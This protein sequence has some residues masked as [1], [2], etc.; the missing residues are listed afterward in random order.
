MSQFW[1]ALHKSLG[2]E[3][4]ASTSYHPQ[5]DGS[6]ERSNKTVIQALR[7]YVNRRQTD[8]AKHLIHVETAMN[9]SVNA[10]TEL[11]PTEL[12][13][14]SPIRLFPTL[15]ETN[16]DDAQLPDV[17]SYID[18]I[19]ESI[20]IAKDNH[21][22]AKTIQ[23]RNANRSR[24]PDPI[25]KVGDMVMLDSKNIRRRITKNGR[26]AKLYP[27]FL[28]PFKIIKAEPETSNY[29]LE[30][31]LRVDFT[32]I[33]PNFHANLLRP[34]IPNDPEQFPRREPPRPDP[35]IPDDPEGAQYTV[36]QLLDHRPERSPREYLVR[37]EGWD[38][39][40]DQW[41]KKKDIHRDLIREYHNSI[42][43]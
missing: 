32:S 29:E 21:I 12:L 31:L 10:T 28:G 5:T 25:Y 34:H 15:D 42:A 43:G 14:G 33:H 18:R 8:W 40:H 30:L 22:T 36:E 7:N 38:E 2:I 13:Y 19:T 35:I 4:Q 3:I 37:W 39:S 6:S 16:T 26:S 11:P 1:K 27:R 41:V 24:R 23:T 17:R 9:N 20:S